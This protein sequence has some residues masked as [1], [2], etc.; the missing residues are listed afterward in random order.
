MSWFLQI[1]GG[2]VTRNA[3]LLTLGGTEWVTKASMAEERR[4]PAC[5]VV[6]NWQDKEEVVAAAGW[7]P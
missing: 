5:G 1:H 3:Y 4:G 6:R 2:D 7:K